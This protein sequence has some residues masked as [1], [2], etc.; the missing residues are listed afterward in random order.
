M[1]YLFITFMITITGFGI[2]IWFDQEP[3][4]K[5]KLLRGKAKTTVF[6]DQTGR[7]QDIQIPVSD[8]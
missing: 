3:G 4:C 8:M 2:P 6:F 1:N 7:K 5:E